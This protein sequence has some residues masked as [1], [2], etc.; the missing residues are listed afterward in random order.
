MAITAEKK[1][2]WGD[3]LLLIGVTIMLMSIFFGIKM[4]NTYDS[5]KDLRT[6]QKI[7]AQKCTFRKDGSASCPK[8]TFYIDKVG[9][10]KK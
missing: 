6:D 8:G 7:I 5:L 10:K 4:S 1:Y 9:V 2:D 3:L